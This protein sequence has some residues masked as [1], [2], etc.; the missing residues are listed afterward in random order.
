MGPKWQS[1]DAF[2][3]WRIPSGVNPPSDLRSLR[4]LYGR[5]P[6][7]VTHPARSQCPPPKRPD[8]DSAICVVSVIFTKPIFGIHIVWG[9][10][11]SLGWRSANIETKTHCSLN[12]KCCER[13]GGRAD[14]RT[15]RRTSGMNP[16]SDLRSLRRL[17]GRKP[18]GVTHPRVAA[19]EATGSRQCDLC[20]K[21]DI[22]KADILHTY[23]FRC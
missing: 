1:L 21:W 12:L 10:T 2:P 19:A 9:H 5:E 13:M 15:N 22:Y 14:G 16:S 8:R 3:K 6:D 23:S 20:G 4:R 18:D 7:G 11:H 17:Y